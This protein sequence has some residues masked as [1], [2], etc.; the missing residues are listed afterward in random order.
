MATGV[1]ALWKWSE[2]REQLRLRER[3]RI[4]A[5]Y[6]NPFLSSCEDLQSRIYNILEL[7]GLRFL[8]KRYPDHGYA[9]ETLYLVVRYFGW[10]SCVLRYGPSTQDPEIIRLTEAV[11]DDF[12]SIHYPVGAFAF[13]RPEQKALGKLVMLRFEGQYGIEMDTISLYDFRKKLE[14]VPLAESLSVQQSISALKEAKSAQSL[15]GRKRLVAVQSH[16]V[17]LL[18][19]VEGKVGFT[20][21]PGDRKKCSQVL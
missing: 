5:L 20:I 10:V 21:F 16:L 17:D 11:R 6:V 14:T 9:E 13:F 2:E 18:S 1:W 15:K 4:A 3:D 19:Y 12:A 7:N 8:R